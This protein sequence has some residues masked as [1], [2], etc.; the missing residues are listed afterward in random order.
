MMKLYN[1]FQPKKKKKKEMKL[2]LFKRAD[3]GETRGQLQ[4]PVLAPSFNSTSN[5]Y[6]TAH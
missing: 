2:P 1:H 4:V 6:K 5:N 3:N